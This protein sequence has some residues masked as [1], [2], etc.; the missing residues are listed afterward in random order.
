MVVCVSCFA[1]FCRKGTNNF[2]Y[3]YNLTVKRVKMTRKR[4]LRAEGRRKRKI[5]KKSDYCKNNPIICLFVPC[6][7]PQ[8]KRT[9]IWAVKMRRNMA[10]G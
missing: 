7:Y 4:W 5:A 9:T 1:A 8:K 10:S 2:H 6:G 3:T